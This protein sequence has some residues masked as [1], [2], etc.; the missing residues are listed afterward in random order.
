VAIGHSVTYT[1][2]PYVFS[3]TFPTELRNSFVRGIVI[4]MFDCSQAEKQLF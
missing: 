1:P 3:A 4:W 2:I